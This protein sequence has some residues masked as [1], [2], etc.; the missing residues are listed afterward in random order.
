EKW[1][2]SPSSGRTVGER[3]IPDRSRYRSRALCP[4]TAPCYR[5][6]Q[7]TPHPSGMFLCDF[8]CIQMILIQSWCKKPSL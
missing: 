5:I 1:P 8:H 3:D 2:K 4:E 6:G 7:Q